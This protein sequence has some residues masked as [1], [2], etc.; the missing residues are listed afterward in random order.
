MVAFNEILNHI[1]IL[2]FKPEMK[3]NGNSRFITKLGKSISLI[4]LVGIIILSFSIILKVFTRKTYSIIYNMDNREIPSV[5]LNE[6]QIAL[7]LTDALGLEI[8]EHDR[9]FNFMAKFW[10]IEFQSNYLQNTTNLSVE[11]YLPKSTIIDLPL[12]NCSKLNFT[13]FAPFYNSI[14][15]AFSSE[16]CIDFSNFNVTLYGRYGDLQGYSTLNVYTR[17]CVN[18]TAANKTNCFPEDKIDKKLS[19]IFF[20]I[21]SIENDIDSNNFENPVLEFTKGELLT[22][23]S[24]IFKN[25]FKD[26][27]VVKFSSNNGFFFDHT[28]F[29]ETYRTDKIMESVDLRGKNTMF[30]GTFSQITFRCSGKTEIY[31]RSYLQFQA[32]FAYITGILQAI[33]LVGKCIIYIF[34]KNS[35]LNYLIMHIFSIDEMNTILNEDF[36]L[37]TKFLL[38]QMDNFSNPSVNN[39]KTKEKQKK[40]NFLGINLKSINFNGNSYALPKYPNNKINNFNNNFQDKDNLSINIQKLAVSNV[41]KKLFINRKP[42]KNNVNK[43]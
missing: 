14:S 22:L 16:V 3:V 32:A 23:S 26:M 43:E 24:T 42:L 37:N 5:K 20:D 34:S 13:K 31:Y 12:K 25:F 17:K 7:I 39:L 19:Q 15:R 1:D 21:I 27:N 41:N 6:T 28:E 38:S 11:S 33:I 40:M 36:N 30:P 10:K 9:Y 35:M 2:S 29:F 4:C 8:K 18:S